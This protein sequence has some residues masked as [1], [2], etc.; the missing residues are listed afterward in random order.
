MHQLPVNSLSF[1]HSNVKWL[2]WNLL[3]WRSISSR[4]AERIGGQPTTHAFA[5]ADDAYMTVA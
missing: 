4:N 5:Y 3:E 1:F 2:G